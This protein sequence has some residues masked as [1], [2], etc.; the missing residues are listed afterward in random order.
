MY[1]FQVVVLRRNGAV[2]VVEVA[3]GSAM[4]L[5]RHNFVLDPLSQQPINIARRLRG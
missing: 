3:I 2:G 4:T 1:I 5:L